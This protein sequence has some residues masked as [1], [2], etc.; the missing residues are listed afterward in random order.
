MTINELIERAHAQAKA[1]GFWHQERNTGELLMLIVSEC[2][3]A[4]EAH[5][6][7]RMADVQEYEKQHALMEESG[8]ETATNHLFKLFIKDTFED[9]LADIVIRIADLCGGAKISL[10]KE[11][12]PWTMEYFQPKNVGELLLLVCAD[13][14]DFYRMNKNDVVKRASLQRALGVVFLIAK[15]ESIDL[16]RH[17]ELKLA[18]NATRPHLHGKAY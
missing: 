18:Y 2:G 13:I 16:E 7:G 3:E 9:E 15:L 5:R 4:L 14:T 11:P 17:I 12:T 1:K 6:K 10:E 8:A